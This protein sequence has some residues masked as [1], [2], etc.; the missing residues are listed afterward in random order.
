MTVT[1]AI[2]T[3]GVPS[4]STIVTARLATLFNVLPITNV[5]STVNVS[6][7]SSIKSSVIGIITFTLKDPAGI[8]TCI[9]VEV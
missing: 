2:V 5:P 7:G 1:S 6:F 8:V 9:V 4:L 3:V